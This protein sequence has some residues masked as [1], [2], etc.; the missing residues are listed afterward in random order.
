MFRVLVP[1]SEIFPDP[2]RNCQHCAGACFGSTY[3]SRLLSI[4]LNQLVS[5]RLERDIS[6]QD[7]LLHSLSYLVS[8]IFTG[9][10]GELVND[11]KRFI[12]NKTHYS[13]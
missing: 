7:Y 3:H 11:D 10:V 4:R 8:R 2:N 9:S 13:L 1:L 12:I 6:G 5:G